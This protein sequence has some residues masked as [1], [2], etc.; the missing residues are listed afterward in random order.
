MKRS[1]IAACVLAAVLVAS[2][3]FNLYQYSQNQAINNQNNNANTKLAM[4]SVLNQLQ[5]Q[6]NAEL[7]NLDDALLSACT[8]LSTKGL[9]GNEVRTVLLDLVAN[10]SL[11]VNA[12]TADTNDMLVAVEPRQYSSIEGVDI[13]DQEQN[14]QMHQTMR[15]AMSNMILLV[16]GFYGV[17]MVAPI[18]NA[19]ATFIGSLSIVIQPYDLLKS[20]ITPAIEGTPYSMWAMQA[21]G[22][23]LYDPDPAQQGKNLFTDPIYVDYPTV[24]AFT[25]KVADEQAG[26]GTYTYHENTVAG[27]IVNKEAYWATIGIYDKEWRLVILHVLN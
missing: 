27:K 20:F 12:A 21:N 1:K 15:P 25:R 23:L 16:E 10:S 14:I 22:T 18:F 5:T 8:Q 13:A 17:V 26:Y 19:N 24:Q 7:Q 4:S 6:V 9:D 2:I 11:I 3:A